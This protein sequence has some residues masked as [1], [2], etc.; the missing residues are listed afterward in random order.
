MAKLTEYPAATQ[1]DSGDILI[2]DGTNGTKKITAENAAADLVSK[3]VDTTLSQAGKAADAAAVGAEIGNLKSE[4]RLMIGKGA[5]LYSFDIIR[6]SYV[7]TDGTIVPYNNWDRTGEIYVDSSKSL[8][9][10]SSGGYTNYCCMY[11]SNGNATRFSVQSGLNRIYLWGNIV[12]IIISGVAGLVDKMLIFSDNSKKIEALNNGTFKAENLANTTWRV[13]TLSDDGGYV[14]NSKRLTSDYIELSRKNICL[15]IHVDGALYCIYEYDNIKSLVYHMGN[16]SNRNGQ[17]LMSPET[18]FIR[19]IIL[20]ELDNNKTL[21]PDDIYSYKLDIQEVS[22]PKKLKVMT[23]NV[24]H[25]HYGVTDPDTNIYWGIPP[26]IY[27]AKLTNWKRLLGKMSASIIGVQEYSSWMNAVATEEEAIMADSVLWDNLYPYKKETG[28]QT[29]LK[30]KE[31]FY[32][33]YN[34]QLSTGRYYTKAYINGVCLLSV[35]LTVGVAYT[36]TRLAEAAEILSILAEE[37]RFIIFGDFN[38][39]PGEED[40]LYA[41]FTSAGCKL[42]NCGFF[43]KYYT[44]S[45]NREDFDHYENPQGTDLY[46]LDNIIVSNNITIQDAYPIPEAYSKLTSDHIPLVAELELF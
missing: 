44:W 38:C 18:K 41:V 26:E 1:F 28:S 3:A 4:S 9:V 36:Q 30:S 39:E 33:S 46:Y 35:H 45:N 37:E 27:D 11:D 10:Y 21:Y 5:D 20:D 34:N 14:D 42:A 8:Y 29:A 25:Y 17:L 23:Y 22:M 40:D 7:A 13:Q 15:D 31:Y 32:W 19:V 2:K 24:G 12:K 16:Y 6:N 43:G